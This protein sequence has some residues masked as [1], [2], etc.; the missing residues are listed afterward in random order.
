MSVTEIIY[1]VVYAVTLLIGTICSLIG[2]INAHKAKKQAKTAEEIE[3]ANKL[4]DEKAKELI[5]AAET[6]YK[7]LDAVLKSTENTTAGTYKKESVMAKLQAYCTSLGQTF[8]EEY[9]SKRID[10]IVS[11]TKQVNVKS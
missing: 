4:I 9:W 10:D 1:L 5:A 11:L 6:F 7:S 3:A 8:D 2:F